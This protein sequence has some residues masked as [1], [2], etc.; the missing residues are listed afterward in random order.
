MMEVD[1]RATQNLT[2]SLLSSSVI[3][4]VVI[5]TSTIKRCSRVRIIEKNMAVKWRA[6]TV[7]PLVE[8]RTSSLSPGQQIH[9]NQSN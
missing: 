9:S 8:M 3:D 2:V 7:Q 4:V 5:R 1:R 6:D